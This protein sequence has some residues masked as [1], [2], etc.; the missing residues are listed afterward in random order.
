MDSINPHPNAHLIDRFYRAF[1]ARDHATMRAAYAPEATFKD[2]VFDLHGPAVGA[3][4]HMFCTS[5]RDL[6]VTHRDVQAGERTGRARWEAR[7]SFGPAARPVHNVIQAQFVFENGRILAHRDS[8]S[9]WRWAAQALGPLGLWLGWTPLVR[10]RVQANA[11]TRL[12]VF[13]A[14]MGP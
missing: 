4:W 9:F 11:R 1:A 3:M 14:G 8:F 12:D 5:S 6:A 13:I 7:Y 2:P 10:R